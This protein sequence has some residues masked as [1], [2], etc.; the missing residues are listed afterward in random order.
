MICPAWKDCLRPI[1]G[2]IA[3]VIVEP[4]AANMGVVL[5]ENGFLEGL[6]QI[7]TERRARF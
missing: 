6:R 2:E 3:A 1:L 4:V 7:C 5:P